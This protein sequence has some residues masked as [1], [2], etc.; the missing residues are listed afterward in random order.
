M[1]FE[2][3]IKLRLPPDVSKIRRT[4]RGHGF[5]ISTPRSLES[6][7]LF[8]HPKDPLGKQ[9]KLIRIRRVGGECVLTFKGPSTSTRYKRRL[10]LEINLSDPDIAEEIFK[11]LGYQPVYRYQKFRAEYI[12]HAGEGKVLLDE[13]P[14]GNFLELE[15]KPRWIDRTAKLLGY[16]SADY[17][18]GSYGYL[19]M[20]YCR[21]HGIQAKD[22]LFKKRPRR[23]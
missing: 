20:I 18:T 3:E 1:N 19:Y 13:T 21:E 14:I 10:E 11:Q 12:Q 7:I 5:R 9:G 6:N 23:I 8:D 2:T 4:L 17:I 22:M 16:S 15:G